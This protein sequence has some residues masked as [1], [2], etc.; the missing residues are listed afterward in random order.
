[1]RY[2]WASAG[3]CAL[4]ILTACGPQNPPE[5]PGPTQAVQPASSSGI[6]DVRGAKLRYVVEGEGLPCLVI[7]SSGYYPR[8]FSADLRKSLKLIFMDLRQFASLDGSFPVENITLETYMEDIEKVREALGIDKVCIIGHSIHGLLAFE[9]AC[10]YPQHTSHV[11]MIGIYPCGYHQ[12]SATT[13]EFWNKEASAERKEA[14]KKNRAKVTEE[15]LKQVSPSEAFAR[16]YAASGPMYWYDY[17][18]DCLKLW[19]GVEVHDEVFNHLLNK[20]FGEYDL[21][22]R[23]SLN[24]AP[25]FLALGR[26]DFVVPYV[27]WDGVKDKVP[28]LTYN[29]FQ[30]SGHTPQYEEPSFFDQKLLEWLKLR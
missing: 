24:T 16:R 9:Y 6:V 21:T 10:H 17:E 26:Y 11:V 2:R 4:F 28:R 12:I 18:F 25:I 8:T 15:I 23:M 30:K 3:I 19:D 27:L 13:R 29:L 14:L 5:A 22:Q 20:I 7:G 1:M